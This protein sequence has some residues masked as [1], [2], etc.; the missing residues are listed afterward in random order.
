LQ[1]DGNLFDTRAALVETAA[2]ILEVMAELV[3]DHVC[4]GEVTGRAESRSQLV[5]EREVDVDLVVE[6]AVERADRRGGRAACRASTAPEQDDLRDFVV[7]EVF[8]P[9]VL[10]VVEHV[11]DELDQ[12]VFFRRRA[13][14]T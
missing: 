5:V 12:I 4:L 14:R 7:G 6:R 1:L 2:Q 13:N 8:R 11:A 3:R 10:D 9:R